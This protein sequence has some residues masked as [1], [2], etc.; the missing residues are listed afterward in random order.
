MVE[1]MGESD[2][3]LG[4]NA[5]TPGEIFEITDVAPG[6]ERFI[7]PVD[8]LR[9]LPPRVAIGFATPERPWLSTVDDI[10]DLQIHPPVVDQPARPASPLEPIQPLRE[11]DALPPATRG[12]GGQHFKRDEAGTIIEN[13]GTEPTERGIPAEGTDLLPITY[14]Q[15]QGRLEALRAATEK[16][17]EEDDDTTDKQEHVDDDREG[18][19]D[20]DRPALISLLL[21]ESEEF[22]SSNAATVE[23]RR[24]DE[25]SRIFTVK[26]GLDGIRYRPIP[27]K[28]EYNEGAED[29]IDRTDVLH[30]YYRT[31]VEGD[32]ASGLSTLPIE[33]RYGAAERAVIAEIMSD[34]RKPKTA[35]Q[36]AT[37]KAA[38]QEAA[39]SGP[40]IAPQR[41]GWINLKLG[42]DMLHPGYTRRFGPEEGPGADRKLSMALGPDR[43]QFPDVPSAARVIVGFDTEHYDTEGVEPEERPVPFIVFP[44][45]N[46]QLVSDGKPSGIPDE[47]LSGMKL[48]G[49]LAADVSGV[50]FRME[51]PE[52]APSIVDRDPEPDQRHESVYVLT[53]TDGDVTTMPVATTIAVTER[54][55]PNA[56]LRRQVSEVLH[57]AYRAT[58]E[59][60]E[61]S[62][63]VMVVGERGAKAYGW[64]LSDTYEKEF[65]GDEIMMKRFPPGSTYSPYDK[66]LLSSVLANHQVFGAP[67]EDLPPEFLGRTLMYME[68]NHA[69]VPMPNEESNGEVKQREERI[70]QACGIS[71]LDEDQREALRQAARSVPTDTVVKATKRWLGDM[72][73]KAV[74]ALIVA[75][76]DPY[77]DDPF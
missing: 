56:V 57:G 52:G 73:G 18:D 43:L 8:D 40:L 1:R 47:R 68:R 31:L 69:Q 50:A 36:V 32:A 55:G 51:R 9:G 35:E 45:L 38:K 28:S 46:G 39:L 76:K 2:R 19:D 13:D 49:F 10:S 48:P 22:D 3:Q 20:S 64:L 27:R 65:L 29:I 30:G 72:T 21:R 67:L 24:A 25:L 58:D 70:L 71:D 17:A 5:G 74:E 26:D 75:V 77:R 37:E 6:S 42:A 44:A 66:V 53:K 41:V 11:P 59:P 14:E 63:D 16:E 12:E 34:G 7:P 60:L 4:E 15:L 33:Q 61:T 23:A 54:T 62:Y